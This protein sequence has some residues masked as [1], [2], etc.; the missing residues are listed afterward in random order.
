MKK[1]LSGTKVDH[2][3]FN[4]YC[5][6]EVLPSLDMSVFSGWDVP[7]LWGVSAAGPERLSPLSTLSA[8]LL[9][10]MLGAALHCTC[11]RWCGCR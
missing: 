10:G 2:T 6:L 3:V 4:H 9:Q 11:Q 7:A 8:L 1:G 5:I